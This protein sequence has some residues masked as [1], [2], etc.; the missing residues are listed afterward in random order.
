L[1]Q[2]SPVIVP[3]PGTSSLSHLEEN[4]GALDVRLNEDELN[5][6]ERYRPARVH[7][8]GASLRRRARPIL[9]P[10][11]GWILRRR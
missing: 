6:L 8:L 11:L 7:A 10:V 4:F 5:A 1:L 9:V 2:R 3:I